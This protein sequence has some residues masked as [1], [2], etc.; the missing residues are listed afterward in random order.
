MRIPGLQLRDQITGEWN[1]SQVITIGV[2]YTFALNAI[3]WLIPAPSIFVAQGTHGVGVTGV[4]WD[5]FVLMLA[6]PIFIAIA[7]I[8]FVKYRYFPDDLDV[9][10]PGQGNGKEMLLGDTMRVARGSVCEPQ[11]ESS[12]LGT[13][14]DQSL[15]VAFNV[16]S[17]PRQ[18][19]VT[20]TR[21]DTG[22]Q[23]E[24]RQDMLSAITGSSVY[25]SVPEKAEGMGKPSDH[26]GMGSPASE[27]SE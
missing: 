2:A 17:L 14:V 6:V 23:V 21:Q 3:L 12:L 18:R 8:L 4:V 5:M 27:L 15:L 24:E 11:T 25:V 22:R 1:W 20:Y 16:E 7:V 10:L 9:D 13:Q 26:P 19:N